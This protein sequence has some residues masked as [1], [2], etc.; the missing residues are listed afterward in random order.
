MDTLQFF[1]NL[2]LVLIDLFT[3]ALIIGIFWIIGVAVLTMARNRQPRWDSIVY[4]ILILVAAIILVQVYP[5]QVI[6]SIRRGMEDARPEAA[7]LRDELGNWLPKWS[8]SPV[9]STAVPTQQA[10]EP[11]PTVTPLPTWTPAP[12]E[13][14]P[15]PVIPTRTPEPPTAV[16]TIDPAIW[17]PATPPPTPGGGK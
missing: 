8:G 3:L 10:P 1:T 11:Q 16:P 14:T 6:R 7:L 17:N 2:L 9:I 12:A 15:P 4:I 13:A 5:E